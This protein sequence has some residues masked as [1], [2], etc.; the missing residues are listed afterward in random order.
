M[1]L[2]T[3]SIQRRHLVPR[4]LGCGREQVITQASCRGC[5]AD[6]LERPARSYAEMEGLVEFDAPP[7]ASD[8]FQE[9]RRQVTL[10]RWLL[11]AFTSAVLAALMIHALGSMWS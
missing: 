2:R 4:C 8:A 10:E 3:S 9:W 6:L 11:T 5:G 7:A 1:R